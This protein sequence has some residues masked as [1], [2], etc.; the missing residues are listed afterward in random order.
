MATLV[1]FD[2][3]WQ[4]YDFRWEES[5]ERAEKE[6]EVAVLNNFKE[7]EEKSL[8]IDSRVS[9]YVYQV[10]RMLHRT[11]PAHQVGLHL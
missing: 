8:P 10:L 1:R 2:K 7:F 6:A 5:T 9:S 4:Q 3:N 11:S